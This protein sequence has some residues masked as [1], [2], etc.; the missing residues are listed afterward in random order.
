MLLKIQGDIFDCQF[1]LMED[2]LLTVEKKLTLINNSI[3]KSSDPESDGLCDHSEYLIGAGFVILQ[4]QLHESL[5]LINPPPKNAFKLGPL[6]AQD[7]YIAEVIN[8]CANYWKHEPE[9]V[10]KNYNQFTSHQK[11]TRDKIIK[12]ANIALASLLPQTKDS[13]KKNIIEGDEDAIY[14]FIE[15]YPLSQ[16]ICNTNNNNE[17]SFV[18]LLQH[19]RDWQKAVFENCEQ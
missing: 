15:S 6:F 8:S 19:V 11:Y 10:G 17:C 1:G 12:Y 5:T 3:Q 14:L 9:W 16:I 18:G 7:L 13:F 4:Q 2:L